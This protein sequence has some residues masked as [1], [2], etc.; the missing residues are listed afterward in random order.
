[1]D[2]RYPN[3]EGELVQLSNFKVM[4]NT[5]TNEILV[6]CTRIEGSKSASHPCWTR[7]QL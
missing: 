2:T 5:E 6:V 3:I 1:M 7:I 4:E